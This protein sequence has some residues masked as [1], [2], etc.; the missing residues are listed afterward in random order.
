MAFK[1]APSGNNSSSNAE[2]RL[3]ALAPISFNAGEKTTEATEEQSSKALSPNE[4]T[5]DKSKTP[6]K[7]LQPENAS[8]P[9]TFIPD[10]QGISKDT[11][12]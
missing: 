6:L 3:N 9:T 1:S 12:P 11:H 10:G 5:R 8:F 2:Q 4:S 7:A